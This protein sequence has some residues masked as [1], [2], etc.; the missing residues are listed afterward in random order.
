ML[1]KVCYCWKMLANAYLSFQQQTFFFLQQKSPMMRP[2]AR[3]KMQTRTPIKILYSSARPVVQEIASLHLKQNVKMKN[4]I[5]LFNHS[6]LLLR[7]LKM[8]ANACKC[9][10]MLANA[11]KCLQMLANVKKCLKKLTNAWKSLKMLAKAWKCLQK[12]TNAWNCLKMLA[13][14]C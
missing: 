12:L 2:I 9:L 6:Q 13:K 3:R 5:F 10:Q 11:W 7:I 8:L 1:A 4:D 14:A